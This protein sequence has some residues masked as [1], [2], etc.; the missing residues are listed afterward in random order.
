MATAPQRPSPTDDD[1]LRRAE[2]RWRAALESLH[3]GVIVH[4]SRRVVWANAAASDLTGIDRVAMD[5]LGSWETN[6]PR[7]PDG[8]PLPFDERPPVV[9]LRTG[10]PVR[11]ELVAITHPERGPRWLLS[12]ATPLL[13]D[14]EVTG[15]VLSFTDVTDRLAA[16]AGL[17]ASEDRYRRLVEQA[18]LGYLVTDRWGQVVEAN[19]AAE[20]LFGVTAEAIVGQEVL[21]W[22]HPDDLALL[23][24]HIEQLWDGAVDRYEVELRIEPADGVERWIRAACTLHRPEPPD[25]PTYL[26][27]LHDFTARRAAQE[28][29]ARLAQV[30][31]STSDLVGL[32]DARTGRLQ[33]LNG[34]ARRLFG[35][36]DVD[37]T[38][39]HHLDL[40]TDAS[41]ATIEQE[42]MRRILDGEPWQGELDM[43]RPDGT[44]VHVWTTMTIE[45]DEHGRPLR[46]SAVGRDVTE[47]RR[48]EQQLTHQ[49]TH[50][51]LT[52]LPNRALLL[53]RLEELLEPWPAP[54]TAVLFLDLDRF[55]AI[56]DTLGHDA[57]DE[58]LRE[59]ARRI[60][61]V[62]RPDDIVARLGG[63]E[64]VVVCPDAGD[65]ERARAL[66]QRVIS[67]VEASPIRAGTAEVAV[68]ASLG[69]ALSAGAAHPESLLRDADAA[70]YRAKELGRAR[71]EV[72]DESMRLRG[73][74]RVVL[75]EELARGLEHNEIVV[76]YQPAIDLTTG[77]VVG[78]E[79]LARWQHPE[80][81]LLSPGEFIGLAEET[82][83]IVGLGLAVL[84][85]ACT[86][87][88]R[89]H[90]QLGDEAPDVHV[91][92]SA[93]Q[94]TTPNVARLVAGVL[95][96]TGLPAT[97]LCLEVTESVLMEDASTSVATLHSLS[98]LGVS[99]AIDDF[100]T[101]YSSLS[102]LRR[103]P[104][105][106]LKV[107]QSF[108]SGLGP[109]AEDSAIVA[110]IVNLASTLDLRAIAE[111]VETLEQLERL[112]T[113][114]CDA[115]QGYWFAQPVPA[116]QL[117]EL[118]TRRWQW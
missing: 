94:L 88:E 21:D 69:I 18:P 104:V 61:G 53:D 49:A 86:E 47:R 45:F 59:V 87:A 80:M 15:V 31:E 118:L 60:S 116:D 16:E 19:R 67:A 5:D 96:R 17:R 1:A 39:I 44:V 102:Y 76:H 52:Q 25:E 74:R 42:A 64:F 57:G 22:V 113:L 4:D 24:E 111:G 35:L 107:D 34:A 63:D 108:V 114:G 98:E 43:P 77:A 13:D 82:G 71:L 56:N 68:T 89:W 84:T 29:T 91:N 109:D 2:S 110:A 38:G 48:L 101:G 20:A 14:G 27:L 93:R 62:L 46:I 55:K 58:L 79:A 73:A 106:V 92:L 51:G 9:A 72:F 85:A 7:R 32:V 41:M 90:R 6:D 83:L 30:I 36:V 33:Y 112:G 81:G 8:T 105:D 95:E 97:R 26:V 66:A 75:A 23:T 70:M 65:E 28:E 40:Y 78:V 100:G 50:D 117:D 99:L 12:N 37:V 10:R 103:F 115:A 54:A 11:D 3:E